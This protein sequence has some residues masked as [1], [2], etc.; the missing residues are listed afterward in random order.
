MVVGGLA[1]LFC[2]VDGF[3]ISRLYFLCHNFP[4]VS[5]LNSKM[6]VEDITS[7]FFLNTEI[8]SNPTRF[9]V[10]KISNII[11]CIFYGNFS[12]AMSALSLKIIDIPSK[13]I[14]KYNTDFVGIS[15]TDGSGIHCLVSGG[16]HS[17]LCSNSDVNRKQINGIAFSCI[18]LLP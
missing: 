12:K 13:Y 5:E 6:T 3:I 17:I 14:P 2:C 8:I 16:S 15:L 4:K 7:E 11:Q 10:Y 1:P 9:K 18:Y